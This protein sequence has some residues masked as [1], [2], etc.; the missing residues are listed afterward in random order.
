M[1]HCENNLVLVISADDQPVL[2]P[3]Q[4]K[5]NQLIKKIGQHRNKLK[6]YQESNEFYLKEQQRV[7]WP[8]LEEFNGYREKLVYTL[9][10][11]YMQKEFGGTEKLKIRDIILTICSAL[12]SEKENPLLEEIYK[13]HT[14]FEEEKITDSEEMIQENAEIRSAVEAFF[15]IRLDDSVDF[16][17]PDAIKAAV[18]EALQKKEQ[19]K[20]NAQAEEFKETFKSKGAKNHSENM[21]KKQ[22]EMQEEEKNISHSIRE[23]YRK[24]ASSLHPDREQDL[25]ERERKTELMQRV[26]TAYANKDLLLL[27]EL[28]LEIE[29][30]DRTSMAR[31]S[32]EKLKHYNKI[33]SEQAK[34]L[35]DEIRQ[36]EFRLKRI[37]YVPKHGRLKPDILIE[38]LACEVNE[39]RTKINEVQKNIIDFANV[40][41]LKKML[42]TY[43]LPEEEEDYDEDFFDLSMMFK[44]W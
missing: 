21:T 6:K 7:Y 9:D 33:L 30:I 13:K 17:S 28:Q 16:T 36:I 20:E 31:L 24:L 15:N 2:S 1:S 4:K 34:E 10:H 14:F 43:S 37:F 40:K 44:F 22:M 18:D 11:A 29:Q 27:L 12:L 32:E 41:K 42:R 19:A 38:V 26:N 3:M 23:I 8:L 39:L 5:F 25:V 35:Q